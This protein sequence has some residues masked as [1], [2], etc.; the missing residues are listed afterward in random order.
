MVVSTPANEAVF[1]LAEPFSSPGAEER[2]K[3]T[4][5]ELAVASKS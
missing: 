4:R 3:G 1:F 5:G 2:E